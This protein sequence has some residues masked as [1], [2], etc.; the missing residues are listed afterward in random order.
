MRRMNKIKT[1]S[2]GILLLLLLSSA[3]A[4]ASSGGSD[5]PLSINITSP[6]NGTSF[7]SDVVPHEVRV[8]ADISSK[9]A[10][11]N[12]TVDSGWETV[13]AGPS[14]HIEESVHVESGGENSIVVTVTDEKGNSVSETTT[15]TIITGPPLSPGYTIQYAVYGEVTDPEGEPLQDCRVTINSSVWLDFNNVPLGSTSM[16]D[17][18][19]NY[20]IENVYGPELMIT[21]DKEG[22]RRYRSVESF[23]NT[24][25]EFNIVMVPE[26]KESPG[27]GFITGISGIAFAAICVIFIH[28]GNRAQRSLEK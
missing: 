16:T 26:E 3:P 21:A 12:I 9:Y 2:I 24:S 7:N 15:F 5:Q 27:F 23:D 6:E 20:L 19:G 14:S 10:I 22:F 17:T 1:I 18:S 28:A 25:V 4:S 8:I 13:E 11:A